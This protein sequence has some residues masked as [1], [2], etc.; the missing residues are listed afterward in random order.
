M[1]EWL[2]EEAVNET[3]FR[4]MNEWAEETSD[5]RLG[6]DRT[7]DD[8]YLCECSDRRCTDPGDRCPTARLH[9]GGVERSR[10]GGTGRRFGDLPT[11]GS[12]GRRAHP[13]TD[14]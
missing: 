8:I 6:L 1:P 5:T 12:A 4:E 2:E 13:A 11:G 10:S 3:I 9:R 7:K 14:R